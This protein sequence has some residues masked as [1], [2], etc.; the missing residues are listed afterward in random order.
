VYEAVLQP[1]EEIE[2]Q[3]MDNIP[4]LDP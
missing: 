2:I 4:S 1:V 3:L